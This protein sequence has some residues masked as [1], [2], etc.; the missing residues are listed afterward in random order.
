MQPDSRPFG[1]NLIGYASANAGVGVTLRNLAK[2]VLERGYPLAILDL[3]LGHG[4][5]G[6]DL[7]LAPYFV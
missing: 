4:R 5:A 2:T 1:F 3:D 6:H 7:S